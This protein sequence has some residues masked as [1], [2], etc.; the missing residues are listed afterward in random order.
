MMSL[1]YDMDFDVRIHAP[2]WLYS[3]KYADG[4]ETTKH[5]EWKKV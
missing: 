4:M 2:K 3:A 1:L 5:E